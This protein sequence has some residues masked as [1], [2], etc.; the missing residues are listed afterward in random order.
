MSESAETKKIYPVSAVN[1]MARMALENEFG[2]L[3]VEGEISRLT[4]SQPG[5]MYFTMKDDKAAIQAAMFRG[6]R[7][8]LDFEPRDGMKVQVFGRLTVYEPSGRLV[9][10]LVSGKMSAGEH[11]IDVDGRDMASGTYFYR[12]KAGDKVETK[13]MTLL[14]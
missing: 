11:R 1:R 2:D 4:V 12:L 7:A 14:K 9:K 3:W 8:S 6:D 10:T 13:R 5:H